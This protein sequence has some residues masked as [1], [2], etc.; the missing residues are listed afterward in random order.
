MLQ[1]RRRAVIIG[2]NDCRSP[3][4]LPGLSYAEKDAIS[5]KDTLTDPVIGTFRTEDVRLVIGARAT[6]SAVKRELRRAALETKQDDI[7][8]IYFSGYGYMT[9]RSHSRNVYLV[10]SDL[11]D[12]SLNE[13][14][15]LGVRMSYLRQDV[16][17]EVE[18]SSLLIVD[19][20]LPESQPADPDLFGAV[21][22][23]RPGSHAALLSC[24]PGNRAKERDDLEHG[25]FT[26]RL[27][28]GLEG[29]A[30]SFNGEVTLESLFMMLKEYPDISPTTEARNWQ[31][32]VA[33]TRPGTDRQDPADETSREPLRPI[34]I[35]IVRHPL[36]PQAESLLDLLSDL[37]TALP[38]GASADG[39]VLE[40]Y[41]LEA[42]RTVLGARGT[43]ILSVSRSSGRKIIAST[44]QGVVDGLAESVEMLSKA[45]MG[46]NDAH[47]IENFNGELMYWVPLYTDREG[48]NQTVLLLIGL[49][50][51]RD[52]LGQPLA[53]FARTFMRP[54]REASANAGLM[55]LGILSELRS[56][57]GRLPTEFEERALRLYRQAIDNL[58][59]IYQPVRRL[60]QPGRLAGV[61]GYEAL[62]R[63]EPFRHS[64]PTWLLQ[65][66]FVWGDQFVVQRDLLIGVRA[67]DT[68]VRYHQS[69]NKPDEP[70]PLS[71]NVSPAALFN[72][73][74]AEAMGQAIRAGGLEGN[75]TLEISENEALGL[76]EEDCQKYLGEFM[77]KYDVSFSIDDFGV[78]HASLDRLARLE[79]AQIK[80]DRAI[81]EHKSAL[82]ELAFIVQLAKQG[83]T[84][85]GLPARKVILEGLDPGIQ[86]DHPELTLSAIYDVGI[87]YV[88]GF[89]NGEPL[90]DPL[91]RSSA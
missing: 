69:L 86:R 71:I 10:T 77:K 29:E 18:G 40:D 84:H 83:L 79:L 50:P 54:K 39:D 91:R 25:Q 11:N 89:V 63:E 70:Q 55:E 22:S 76:S 20:C 33:L 34:H 32:Y 28:K 88:Q 56:N 87:R 19:C 8:V 65:L 24:V 30:A 6:S 49:P 5:V 4:V 13:D 26:H 41:K 1:A 51:S 27:L 59:V 58:S 44:G 12:R 7:L 81:L 62:A 64:A 60:S 66:A 38:A 82:Q 47:R 16:L 21:S 85:G 90:R 78:G 57:L 9:P 36:D 72:S 43:A 67:I 68:Y 74:Y 73:R 46:K 37:V 52:Q 53:I 80:I 17:D 35:G 3:D 45:S 31:T 23:L 15:D 75:L 14:P 48:L 2:V 42:L 61:C